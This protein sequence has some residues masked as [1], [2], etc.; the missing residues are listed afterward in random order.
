LQS[1]TWVIPARN[2]AQ[3]IEHCLT[4]ILEQ[5]YPRELFEVI[6]VDDG[7]T[8]DTAL[9]AGKFGI[10]IL[11]QENQG[12]AAARNAG[13]GMGSKEILVFTDADCAPAPTFLSAMAKVFDDPRVDGA[14]GAYKTHQSGWIPRFVQQEF[15]YKQRRM[16]RMKSINTVHTYAAAYRRSVFIESG[17]FDEDFP[18]PSNED[19]ELSYR[20]VE[21]GHELV[22]VPSAVVF[23]IHD[24]GLLEFVKRKYWL[25]FWKALTLS[26]H[27]Q[28]L[29]GDSHSPITQLIQ[30]GLVPV[31]V[32]SLV[33]SLL[34]PSEQYFAMLLIVFFIISCLP[35]TFFVARSDPGIV[36]LAPFLLA[37]RALCQASGL[38]VG[39][40]SQALSK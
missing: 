38:I 40:M 3:N 34:I 8:D 12:P 10:Q 28:H 5:D 9:I 19:Q 4:S 39:F 33:V 23:H 1:F 20:L 18:F 29:R 32:L 11:R 25:G 22:F 6:L 26:K 7:S 24:R 13:A 35:L 2:E 27:P 17:G 15:E 30:I 14:M 21:Q 16:S 31:I 37:V 36:F